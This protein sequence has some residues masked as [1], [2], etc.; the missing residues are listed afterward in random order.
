[1]SDMSYEFERFSSRDGFN[2]SLSHFKTVSSLLGDFEHSTNLADL[3]NEMLSE[4]EIE[5]HQLGPIIYALLVD[6]YGYVSTSY[7]ME[8]SLSDFTHIQDETKKWNSVDLVMT[9]FHPE[10]G[11]MIINP[12]NKQNWESVN[13][14]KKNEIVTGVGFGFAMATPV[15]TGPATSAYTRP[16]WISGDAGTDASDTSTPPA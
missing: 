4:K 3:L 5:Q 13:V 15:F 6:K 1:M 12:K 8:D 9:Y 14:F 11:L 2:R 7:N 10:L 16:D